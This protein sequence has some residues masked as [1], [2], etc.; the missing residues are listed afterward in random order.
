MIRYVL[1]GRS[2]QF[3][4]LLYLFCSTSLV[5]S[6]CATKA[7]FLTSTV[8]PAATGE[9]KVKKDGNNNYKIEVDVENLAEPSRLPQP[10]NVYVVWAE[11]LQGL[12]NLGQLKTSSGL[13][14][15]KMKASLETITPYKPTRVFIT[16]EGAPNVTTP[17]YYTVLNTS[18]LNQ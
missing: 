14:S 7:K 5:F 17:G 4:A 18:G 6:S 15:S 13:L 11:T 16:A 1:N 2:F 9:V 12:Q 3:F 10:Q 8:V